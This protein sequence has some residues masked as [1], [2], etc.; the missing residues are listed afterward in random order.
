MTDSQESAQASMEPRVQCAEYA[1]GGGNGTGRAG[2]GAVGASYRESTGITGNRPF[3]KGRYSMEIRP[4]MN[5]G[6]VAGLG[7]R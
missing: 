1:G 4:A 2:V 5:Q 3:P 7:R 6:L